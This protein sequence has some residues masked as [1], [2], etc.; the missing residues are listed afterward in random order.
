MK[1]FQTWILIKEISAWK[2]CDTLGPRFSRFKLGGFFDV[3]NLWFKVKR[4]SARNRVLVIVF[5]RCLF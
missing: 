4:K 5:F 2:H 1:E 3:L